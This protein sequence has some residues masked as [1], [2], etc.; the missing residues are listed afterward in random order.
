LTYP[1]S[2]LIFSYERYWQS[3][4]FRDKGLQVFAKKAYNKNK[5]EKLKETFIDGCKEYNFDIKT[6]Y[7]KFLKY[8]K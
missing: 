1:G 4:S 5:N 2:A 6:N 7:T 3:F 8:Y